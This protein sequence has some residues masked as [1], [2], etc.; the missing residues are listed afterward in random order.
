MTAHARQTRIAELLAARG[1]CSVEFL[2][3]RLGVSGMTVRRDLQAMADAGKVIRTH[4]GATLGERV[5]FEFQFLAR[6]RENRAAKEAIAAAAAA[7]VKDGQSVMLDSGTTTLALAHRLTGRKGLTVITTSLPI[8]SKLQFCEQV[9]VLLL[10]G[11][12]QR[13]A[14]DL[15]GA[16]T[17]SNLE[18]LHADIAFIGADGIDAKGNVYN[19]SLAVGRMLGKMAAS[20][21]RVY[22]V[23]DSSKIG[24]TAL[25]RFG[26]VAEWNG[27]ITDSGL[28]KTLSAALK[29]TGVRIITSRKDTGR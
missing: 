2:A 10:G 19:N 8:A 24:R 3:A 25:R 12:V 4:G 6:T 23:A 13:G 22:A 5:T 18:S 26:N 1:E 9:Q 14:P 16:L 27:L 29:R 15:A 17:E 21:D 7:L 11:L 20:A 28:S